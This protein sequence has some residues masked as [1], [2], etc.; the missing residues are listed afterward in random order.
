MTLKLTFHP[1]LYY[2]ENLS[3]EEIAKLKRQLCKK[4]LLYDVYVV[5]ASAN[6]HN[7]LEFFHCRFLAQTYYQKHPPYVIGIASSYQGATGL[8]L[9]ITEDCLKKR[10]DCSLREYLLC[11]ESC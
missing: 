8:V 9:R 6:P 5:T 1:D 2:D 11:R 3:K 4:P 7:Q 10:G